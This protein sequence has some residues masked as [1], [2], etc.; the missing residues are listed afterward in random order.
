MIDQVLEDDLH[1]NN[2]IIEDDEKL[3]LKSAS[4]STDSS[5]NNVEENCEIMQEDFNA[6]A[7]NTP[8]GE[9]SERG[10]NLR[11]RAEV[12]YTNIYDH[13]VDDT[14]NDQNYIVKLL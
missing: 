10:Y 8:R 9:F 13:A 2:E 3:D 1:T 14:L 5:K 11:S 7:W 6:A 12:D 4:Q